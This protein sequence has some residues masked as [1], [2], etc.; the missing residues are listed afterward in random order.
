[1]G[2][3]EPLQKHQFAARIAHAVD[4]HKPHQVGR[5]EGS[6]AGDPETIEHMVEPEP[7]PRLA[8]GVDVSEILGRQQL[9]DLLLGDFPPQDAL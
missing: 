8:D 2:G 6:L 9:A 3:G 5:R 7:V 1:M 4:Q